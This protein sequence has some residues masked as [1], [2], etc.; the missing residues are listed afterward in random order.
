MLGS[1]LGERVRRGTTAC[2]S[3]GLELH[4]A[5]QEGLSLGFPPFLRWKPLGWGCEFLSCP[6]RQW[7]HLSPEEQRG[8]E[9]TRTYRGQKWQQEEKR[10]LREEVLEKSPW[11]GRRCAGPKAQS[12]FS[13]PWERVAVAALT[14]TSGMGKNN[15]KKYIKKS[16]NISISL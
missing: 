1:G 14:D 6:C 10:G 9:K 13:M 7:D 11:Q 2:G 5:G 8:E 3:L 12:T 16:I 4:C 15:K